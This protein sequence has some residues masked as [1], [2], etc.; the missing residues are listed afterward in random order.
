[1]PE[2]IRKPFTKAEMDEIRRREQADEPPRGLEEEDGG[3]LRAAWAKIKR[4]GRRLPFAEDLVAAYF[5]AVDSK[6]PRRVR[7]VLM[8][9]LAYFVLPTDAVAD[10]LPLIGFGD[11]AAVL[12][13]AIAQVAAHITPEHREKARTALD[14]GDER[15]FA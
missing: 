6:T 2:T 15:S 10:F 9:A 5:C 12:A 14:D 13:A 7:Y 3:L 8:G 4:F 11:D 1:M